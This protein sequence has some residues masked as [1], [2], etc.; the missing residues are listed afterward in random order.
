MSPDARAAMSS[1]LS[2]A[3]ADT[4]AT[5][6]TCARLVAAPPRKSAPPYSSAAASARTITIGMPPSVRDYL[7]NFTSHVRD[8]SKHLYGHGVHRRAG[9]SGWDGGGGGRG[10]GGGG[11][12]G[13]CRPARHVPGL[14]EGAYPRLDDAHGQDLHRLR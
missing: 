11:W 1:T 13:T 4:A 12:A 8:R 6:S 2:P 9:R 14:G 5:D 10:C 7:R 3:V